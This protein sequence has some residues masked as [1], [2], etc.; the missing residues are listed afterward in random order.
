VESGKKDRREGQRSEKRTERKQDMRR[1]GLRSGKRT[2]RKT[3]MREGERSREDRKSES[4]ER[5]R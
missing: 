4:Y 3:E 5:R 2:E 1:E